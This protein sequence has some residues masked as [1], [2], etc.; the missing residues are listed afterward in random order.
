LISTPGYANLPGCGCSLYEVYTLDSCDNTITQ[1][2][3]YRNVSISPLTP[4]QSVII[5]TNGGCFVVNSYLGIK[6]IYPIVSGISPLILNSYIDCSECIT[7]NN[8]SGGGGG[9]SS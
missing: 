6:N 7:F 3:A 9:E 8:Q 2:F 4:G 1:K 5:D